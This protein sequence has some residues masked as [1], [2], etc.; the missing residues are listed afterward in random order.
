[1]GTADPARKFGESDL[2]S[3]RRLADLGA[4]ALEQAEM[5][6]HLEMSIGSGVEALTEAIDM[7]DNYTWQHSKNVSQLATRVA[8]RMSLSDAAVAELTL[9][10]KL[11]DVGKVALP[12]VILHKSGPL[13]E[14]E[15]EIMKQYP[16]RGAEMLERVPGLANVSQIVLCEQEHW[17]G[18]GYPRG[19]KGE[20]IPL[21]SRIILA[22]DAYD[23]M[24][25]DRPWRSALKAWAACKE[26]RAG[27]GT[28]FD[29]QVVVQ[30][31][32]VLRESRSATALAALWAPKARSSA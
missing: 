13:T 6:E 3:L 9:A 10:A 14:D 18:G 16:L 1:V 19:L 12:D 22:C 8:E 23:A 4:V 7:R 24:V 15:W 32:G 21:A 30:L 2:E 20:T 31:I 17:D 29:P 27:A 5:R 28:Q 25:S 11:H 26:L